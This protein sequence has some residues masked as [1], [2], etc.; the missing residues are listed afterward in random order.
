MAALLHYLT[1]F[2]SFSSRANNY[3]KVVEVRPILSATK[4]VSD[5]LEHIWTL[6]EILEM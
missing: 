2:N 1:I 6:L 4:I 3:I 5:I